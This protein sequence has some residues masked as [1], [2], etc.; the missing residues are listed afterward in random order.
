MA[1]QL[2]SHRFRAEREAGWR[3]LESL[4]ARV[5]KGRVQSLSDEELLAL[6]VL[7]RSTLSSLSVARATSLDA[8][9]IAYL[10]ALSARAYVLVYGTRLKPLERAGA[11]FLRDWPAAVRALW[12]ETAVAFAILLLA[13]AAGFVLV[14]RDADWFGSIIPGALSQ[15]RDPTASTAFL[16][17]VLYDDHKGQGL[18]GFAAFLFT[19]N[20]QVSLLAFALGFAFCLP[21]VLLMADNG[22]TLGALVALYTQRGLGFPLGGWLIIHGATE[23]LATVL[24]GAAGL[25]IG[26]SVIFPGELSRLAAA[27]RAG[28]AAGLVMGGVLVMLVVAAVLEGIGRQVVVADA[29]RWSIGGGSLIAWLAYFYLPRRMRR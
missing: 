22:L 20:A 4:L 17:R 9:L 7:Y 27:S 21:T 11:F 29:V 18:S 14:S 8:G 24:A 6:P 2:R 3:R 28:R 23:I 5:E 26:W 12:R 10:E 1:L 13:A 19:H 16:R 15:G 25:H